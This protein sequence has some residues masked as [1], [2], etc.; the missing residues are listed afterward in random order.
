MSDDPNT[1][2]VHC[3]E[4]KSPHFVADLEF[5]EPDDDTNTQFGWLVATCPVCKADLKVGLDKVTP[6]FRLDE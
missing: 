4:C 3:T 5:P 2:L 1:D 6:L